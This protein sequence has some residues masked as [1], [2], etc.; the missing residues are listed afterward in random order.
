MV[1][2]IS[3][4][5]DELFKERVEVNGLMK[6]AQTMINIENNQDIF[7]Q[8]FKKN[9]NPTT[10]FN[11]YS[12]NN[13]LYE[14]SNPTHGT[15]IIYSDK[16]LTDTIHRVST[17]NSP[18]ILYL[19]NKLRDNLKTIGILSKIQPSVESHPYTLLT[20]E[21]VITRNIICTNEGFK[22]NYGASFIW[23][24]TIVDLHNYNKTTLLTPNYSTKSL[25]DDYLAKALTTIIYDSCDLLNMPYKQLNYPSLTQYK[26]YQRGKICDDEV[27]IH[28]KY[29]IELELAKIFTDKRYLSNKIP[30]RFIISEAVKYE[31]LK[32]RR[33]HPTKDWIETIKEEYNYEKQEKDEIEL[34]A[35][36]KPVF[37]NNICFISKMPLS[38]V[39]IASFITNIETGQEFCILISPAM[40][41]A[42]D[43][44][45]KPII[46]E[47][48][49]YAN[50]FVITSKYY[51]EC[52]R[53]TLEV[54]DIIPNTVNPVKKKIL[55]AIEKYGIFSS[56]VGYHRTEYLTIDVEEQEVYIG[57]PSFDDVDIMRYKNTN[58]ILYYINMHN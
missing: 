27:T 10:G 43:N 44:D 52:P 30:G 42:V 22:R 19:I 48:I 32:I 16:R 41:F 29:G 51:V 8:D 6:I 23:E 33:V 17:R 35:E 28:S 58:A 7:T 20:N 47:H 40:D 34:V 53:S 11:K 24:I 4:Q 25:T 39:A 45:Y 31:S 2:Y 38:S 3:A 36:G 26:L 1:I 18:Q 15:I 50:G 56:K 5:S 9:Q 46:Y 55:K 21:N 14:V 13:V 54:I 37:P 57:L 49:L 12:A